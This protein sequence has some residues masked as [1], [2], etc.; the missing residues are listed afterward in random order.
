MNYFPTSES[1]L[2]LCDEL[3]VDVFCILILLFLFYRNVLPE[4]QAADPEA[5]DVAH[6]VPPP[7]A[8]PALLRRVVLRA[9]PRHAIQF[10]R[11]DTLLLHCF[12][13]FCEHLAARFIQT[14]EREQAACARKQCDFGEVWIALWF[15]CRQLSDEGH[16]TVYHDKEVPTISSDRHELK[17][18]KNG[19]V[20]TGAGGAI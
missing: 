14:R 7:R 12:C 6:G 2:E 15:Y 4:C 3:N 13:P 16:I 9:V 20:A 1:S 10:C 8:A 19:N 5:L 18:Y 17:I 11:S